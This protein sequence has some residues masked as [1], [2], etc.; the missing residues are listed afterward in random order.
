MP[1]GT[2]VPAIHTLPVRVYYE[3]TDAGGVVYHAS[4]LRFAERGRTEFLRA[5][6]WDHQRAARELGL[7][8][9]VRRVEA[10]YR[11]PARLDDLLEVC[12]ESPAFGN[13]SLAMRQTILRDG[14]PLAELNTVIVAMTP[15]GKPLRVPPQL[16][17]I[18]ADRSSSN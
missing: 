14:K 11:A 12:T 4:Y 1:Q 8:L 3:D 17:Q 18:F 16:R 5:A 10:D 13:T 7:L 6:G 9:V 15:Q 2:P